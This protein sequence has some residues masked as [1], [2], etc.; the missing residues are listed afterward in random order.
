VIRVATMF[1]DSYSAKKELY[2][3]N[4]LTALL[5]SNSKVPETF[6]SSTVPSVLVTAMVQVKLNVD[7]ETSVMS[8]VKTFEDQPFSMLEI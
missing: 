5:S 1:S 2:S 8:V 7:I 6:C 3:L 4:H